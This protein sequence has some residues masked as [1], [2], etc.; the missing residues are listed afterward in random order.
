M[1]PHVSKVPE[2]PVEAMLVVGQMP[3][4]GEDE[5]EEARLFYATATL[6]T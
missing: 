3:V 6:A 5:F 1:A 2:F 4:E